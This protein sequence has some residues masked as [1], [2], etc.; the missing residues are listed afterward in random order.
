MKKYILVLLA[1]VFIIPSIAFASWYNPFTWNWFGLFGNNAPQTEQVDNP[2][3]QSPTIIQTNIP[4][5]STQTPQNSSVQSNPVQST[6]QG[7][8]FSNQYLT[9]T[10]PSDWT[11]KEA[12]QTIQNKI[13]NKT[14]GQTILVGSPVVEKTGA[15]NITKGNYILYIN[16]QTSQVSGIQGGRFV[17]IAGGAPS[18][19]AVE[20][21]AFA[22]PCENSNITN[23]LNVNGVDGQRTDFYVGPNDTNG[24]CKT[25][26][27]RKDVW[28]FSFFGS[29]ANPDTG[30]G[31]FN[32]YNGSPLSSWVATMAYNSKD[33]NA[34]P[35][36]D[37][38]DLNQALSQMS[39]I[40]KTLKINTPVSPVTSNSQT[41]NTIDENTITKSDWG[42]S[43]AKTSDWNITG[44]AASE[45]KLT[46][47]SGEDAGDTM[48]IDY[49]SGQNIM[50]TDAKFGTIT[51]SYDETK[52]IW[53]ETDNEEGEGVSP[54]T[55]PV[56]ATTT[57][58][59]TD[60]L[61][62]FTGTGRWLTYII[63]ISHTTFLKLN[64]TGSGSTQALEDLVKT[65][66][67]I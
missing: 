65:L 8:V 67:K 52:Q 13:Y 37:S 51:F 22:E 63:P 34:L 15:V 17:E 48:T 1:V 66:K 24:V 10:I 27:N 57:I 39:Y 49:V 11:L 30:A 53:V 35:V 4:V 3:S 18:V 47:A 20:T 14:T 23:A 42:V 5:S 56:A 19:D 64:I 60:N 21:D 38:A 7:A 29:V 12:T 31:Y 25:P 32:Q 62:V 6:T 16:P 54:H 2:I 61:P 44:N 36:K 28:Y 55:T 41:T 43:F 59:T 9:V 45:V 46:E 50:D 33:I 26:K 40:L 58:Y